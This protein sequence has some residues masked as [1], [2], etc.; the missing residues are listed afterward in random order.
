[1]LK[2]VLE[3]AARNQ[4]LCP[5]LTNQ[6]FQNPMTQIP[7][8]LNIP[9]DL[10][11]SWLKGE[12]SI[13]DDQYYLLC[14]YLYD[15]L[16]PGPGT[17]TQIRVMHPSWTAKIF[18]DDVKQEKSVFRTQE[19]TASRVQAVVMAHELLHAWRMMAGRRIVSGGWEEEA[20]TTGCGPFIGWKLTENTFRS[21]LKLSQR[22]KYS[23]PTI[24]SNSTQM[25]QDQTDRGLKLDH[26][27]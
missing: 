14:C 9:E 1:V 2:Q 6:F 11:K 22:K 3:N 7:R 15:Y 8:L 4:A 24:S 20:M 26:K 10:L 23:C 17:D 25:L 12:K 19:E 27:F 21:A 18:K 5:R 13:K 16:V